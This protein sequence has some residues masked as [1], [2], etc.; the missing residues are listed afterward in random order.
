MTRNPTTVALAAVMYS[1]NLGDGVIAECISSVLHS[2]AG[3]ASTW[4]DL[5]GRTQFETGE[6]G[7][8][9]VKLR[10]LNKI[11]A[12]RPPQPVS[13]LCQSRRGCI[14]DGDGSRR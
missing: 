7:A 13:A 2:E 11:H 5:A 10:I 12:L 4:L 9:S 6:V 14:H 3:A 8:R 1:P